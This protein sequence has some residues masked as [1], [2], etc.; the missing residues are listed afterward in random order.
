MKIGEYLKIFLDCRTENTRRAYRYSWGAW[1]QSVKCPV[2]ATPT[3]V[4]RF[5]A[6][7]RERVAPDGEKLGD[8]TIRHRFHSLRSI[9][10]FLLDMGVVKFNPFVR[11]A[12]L[13]SWRQSVQKRPTQLLDESL[14]YKILHSQ[15]TNT[16]LGLQNA[17]LFGF[18][19]GG[20]LRRGEVV[21]IKIR[22]VSFGHNRS[23]RVT[24]TRTKAGKVQTQTLPTWVYSNISKLVEARLRTGATPDSWLFVSN[25]GRRMACYTLYRRYKKILKA[26]G[27]NAAPHSA[28]A[29]AC[30]QLL[31]HGATERDAAIFLRHNTTQQ[32]AVYDKRNRELEQNPGQWISYGVRKKVRRKRKK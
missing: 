22:D 3:D 21:K 25:R 7:L 30:T 26:H 17:A 27:V 16:A 15:N 32:V 9:Y 19:F 11:A 13:I 2:K 8:Q 4:I 10:S 5:V 23:V 31:R 14:I 18:L 12:R 1:L 29:S 20:G 28:R 24:L 6:T